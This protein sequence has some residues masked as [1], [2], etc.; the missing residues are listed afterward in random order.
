[1]P[2][3]EELERRRAVEMKYSFERSLTA[4]EQLIEELPQ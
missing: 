1:M 2:A 3:M 4:Y